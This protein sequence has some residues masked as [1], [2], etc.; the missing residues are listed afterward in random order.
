[1]RHFFTILLI[2]LVAIALIAIFKQPHMSPADTDPREQADVEIETN[3]DGT[4]QGDT[5]QQ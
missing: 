1:M 3:A 2:L 5:T 4:P